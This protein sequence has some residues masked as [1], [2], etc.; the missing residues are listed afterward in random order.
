MC[1]AWVSKGYALPLHYSLYQLQLP[2]SHRV[3]I[4]SRHFLNVEVEVSRE[5]A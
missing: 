2:E 3:L 5:E 4:L 1:G